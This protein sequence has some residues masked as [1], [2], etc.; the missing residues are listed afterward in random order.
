M[1]MPTLTS[2]SETLDDRIDR[3]VHTHSHRWPPLHSTP[4]HAVIGEIIEHVVGLEAAIHEIARE[5]QRLTSDRETH[6]AN[7][8]EE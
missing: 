7:A 1:M 2:P 5:L 3:L 8:S 4:T 6:D